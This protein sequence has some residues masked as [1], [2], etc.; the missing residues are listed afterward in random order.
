[1]WWLDGYLREINK[2]SDTK[3]VIKEVVDWIKDDIKTNKL[4]G[5]YVVN[6]N[7]IPLLFSHAGYSP[8]FLKYLK[9]K[10]KVADNVDAI[11]NYTNTELIKD[12]NKCLF[13]KCSLKG[14]LYD[15]GP[16]RYGKGIGGP[17]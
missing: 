2:Q 6:I 12:V 15:A 13:K 1:M 16:E 17:L 9:E 11:A 7:G 5:S 8:A 14:E 3:A 10:I 4:V